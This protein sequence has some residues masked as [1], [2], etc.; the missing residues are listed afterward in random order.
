MEL[1]TLRE[2]FA[3]REFDSKEFSFDAQDA[4]TWARACGET[5]AR[6]LDS[7]HPDFQA[8]PTITAMFVGGRTLPEDY[9]RDAFVNMFDA[10]KCVTALAPIRPGE[11]IVGKSQIANFYEKT[12]RSGPMLFMVHRMEFFDEKGTLVSTVDW[13]LVQRSAPEGQ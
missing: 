5:E 10:G 9:P 6:Y 8:P 4:I 7:S 12:G 1:V 2:Q 3:G 11:R 13:R